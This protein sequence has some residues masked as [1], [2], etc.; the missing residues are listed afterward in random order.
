MDYFSTLTQMTLSAFHKAGIDSTL[1]QEISSIKDAVNK[2][3]ELKLVDAILMEDK[4]YVKRI[5][6]DGSEDI[7]LKTELY[8]VKEAC[9]NILE[10]DVLKCLLTEAS[11][12]SRMYWS[13]Y[14]KRMKVE[15]K[16]IDTLSEKL[17]FF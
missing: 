16:K 6:I 12:V 17:F 2:N 13:R 10:N 9:V 1:D 15:R 7:C 14:C 8:S 3:K 5:F 4:D 11:P